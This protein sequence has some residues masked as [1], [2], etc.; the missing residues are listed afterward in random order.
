[1]RTQIVPEGYVVECLKC[2][3]G[4]LFAGQQDAQKYAAEHVCKVKR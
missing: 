1:M 3:A 2:W 4:R